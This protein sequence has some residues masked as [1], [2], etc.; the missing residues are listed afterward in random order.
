MKGKRGSRGFWWILKFQQFPERNFK[1]LRKLIENDNR[2]LIGLPAFQHLDVFVA[3][4]GFFGKLFLG[5]IVL[6][7]KRNNPFP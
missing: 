5:E 3:D 1:T 6:S 7:P 2:C 4:A